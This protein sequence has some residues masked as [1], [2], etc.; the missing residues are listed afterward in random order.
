MP[1]GLPDLVNIPAPCG[2]DPAEYVG[3]GL[4]GAIYRS[5]ART[6]YYRV[7]LT[8]DAPG[9]PS[10]DPLVAGVAEGAALGAGGAVMAAAGAG[11]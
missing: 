3:P 5:K 10:P 1:A 9:S 8:R 7:L 11:G 4:W 2:P 6:A